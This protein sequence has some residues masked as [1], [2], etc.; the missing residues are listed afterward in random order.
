VGF[1]RRRGGQ[2]ASEQRGGVRGAQGQPKRRGHK[3]ALLADKWLTEVTC[4]S[5]PRGSR[6]KKK[7]PLGSQSPA[8]ASG[9][10]WR[11]V[12]R[13]DE[14]QKNPHSLTIASFRL[15]EAI[16]WRRSS[17]RVSRWPL[18]D[19]AHLLEPQG[20]AAGSAQS[21]PGT[22][23]RARPLDGRAAI[24]DLWRIKFSLQTARAGPMRMVSRGRARTPGLPR[25]EVAHGRCSI[26]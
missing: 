3:V 24:H 12:H 13:K 21:R 26:A 17:P 4:G 20:G 16:G 6:L 19:A 18:H 9:G 23:S 5:T 1:G 2:C 22:P 10:A 7:A 11:S 14:P 25:S 15:T 8:R